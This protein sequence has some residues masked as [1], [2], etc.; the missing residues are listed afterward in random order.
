M[1]TIPRK[2]CPRLSNRQILISTREKIR[3][4]AW[5]DR[6]LRKGE[7]LKQMNYAT[8]PLHFSDHRPVYAIFQCAV[9]AVN[10]VRKEV[11]SRELYAKRSLEI[12]NS[13]DNTRNDDLE[14]E[15]AVRYVSIAPELPPASS[16]RRKWWLDNGKVPSFHYISLNTDPLN[17][18]FQLGRTLRPQTRKPCATLRGLKVPAPIQVN[19]TGMRVRRQPDEAVPSKIGI[20]IDYHQLS[21]RIDNSRLIV[22]WIHWG[23]KPPT[24]DE[25]WRVPASRQQH[26]C[27]QKWAVRRLHQFRRNLLYSV[28]DSTVDKT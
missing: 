23:E 25:F 3:I 18:A 20:L 7:I 4:P 6:I 15:D 24:V 13:V 14:C 11:L 5:C 17:Q 2:P 27:R 22:N 28:T 16:D 8:A 1:T 19:Q 12:G 9:S 21:M 26:Q 10:I